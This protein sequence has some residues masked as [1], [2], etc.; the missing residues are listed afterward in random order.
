ML[1]NA[2]ETIT[3]QQLK[4]AAQRPESK[5]RYFLQ[6]GSLQNAGDAD[7]LKAKLA[8]LG[9][10]ATVQAVNVPEKKG[11]WHGCAWGHFPAL[12]T[13]SKRAPR[14][15]KMESKVLS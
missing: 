11:V 3:E 6:A 15:S 9:M 2:E 14:C 13:L 8:M 7:N 10:E 5:D 1:P 4:Q 12:M